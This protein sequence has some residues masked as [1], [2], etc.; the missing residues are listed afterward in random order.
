MVFGRILVIS[1]GLGHDAAAD[2]MLLMLMTD[3]VRF[4]ANI[5]VGD[6]LF[7]I[8]HQRVPDD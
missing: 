8:S 6:C 3:A 7:L 1:F 2:D 5:I 4:Y